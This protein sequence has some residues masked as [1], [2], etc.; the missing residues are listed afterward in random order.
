MLLQIHPDNPDERKI[1]IISEYLKDGGVIIYPSDTVYTLG[2]D[3]YQ[4]KAV[5]RISR[6][7]GIDP[8]KANY[9]FICSDL[10][11]LSDFVFSIGT[12]LYRIMKK[13][14]P[15]P[16]TFILRANN[17]VPKIFQSKKKTVGIRIPNNKI[18]K[19][20]VK[21]LGNP[22]MSSS[23]HDDDNIL[24]YTTDPELIYDKYKDV[25]DIVIDGGF[26]GKIPSTVLDCSNEE[27]TIVRQGLGDINE[28]I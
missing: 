16:F 9:S 12:P 27:M 17:N 13:A 4:S 26:G 24:G 7:K 25:V 5:E 15:G 3:I 1:R 19:S 20:I 28:Y 8:K 22:I 18:C 21:E 6:L 2:C 11:H 10:S 14:T 23:I